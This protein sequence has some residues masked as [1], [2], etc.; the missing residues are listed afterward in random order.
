MSSNKGKLLVI[1]GGE[2]SGKGTFIARAKEIFSRALFTRE[3][4]GTEYAEKMR[5]LV[6]G[7]LGKNTSSLSQLLA[8]MSARADHVEKVIRPAIEKGQHV[9][10]DRFDSATWAYQIVHD[11]RLKNI[12][13]DIRKSILGGKNTIKPIYV[14]L[15]V[16]PE[17]GLER[18]SKDRGQ[19]LNHFDL[20]SVD[21]HTNVRNGYLEFLKTLPPKQ[22]YIINAR[23]PL[24]EVME[25]TIETVSKILN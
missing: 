19:K 25:E 21:F 14:Y 4:G 23:R 16:N 11:K 1:D 20:Q 18:R 22:S 7:G 9:I 10:T 5:E 13:H 12:F 2:G 3:P 15:D 17:V 24:E 8:V 6:L